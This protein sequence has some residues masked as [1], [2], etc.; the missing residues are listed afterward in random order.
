MWMNARS[1]PKALWCGLNEVDRLLRA[2]DG[3]ARDDHAR[4]A[5]CSGASDDLVAIVIEA[6]MREIC[7][8]VDD[9]HVRSSKSGR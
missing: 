9:R 5:G 8:D 3:A 4:D 6:V 7:A 1:A 2:C